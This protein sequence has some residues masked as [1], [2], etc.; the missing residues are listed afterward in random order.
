MQLAMKGVDGCAGSPKQAGKRVSPSRII[1]SRSPLKVSA[2][3][4]GSEQQQAQAGKVQQPQQDVATK[5]VNFLKSEVSD[6]CA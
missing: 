6:T 2:F 1:T 5:F 4:P 3:Q